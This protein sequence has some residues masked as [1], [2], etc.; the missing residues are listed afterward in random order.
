MKNVELTSFLSCWKRIRIEV[1]EILTENRSDVIGETIEI[2][3]GLTIE[4]G[5]NRLFPERHHDIY[6]D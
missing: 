3:D 2:L 1:I 6:K 4:G 5:V